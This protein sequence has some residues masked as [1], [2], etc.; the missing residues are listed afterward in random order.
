MSLSTLSSPVCIPHRPHLTAM[1]TSMKLVSVPSL[2][3]LEG[4]CGT[5]D[6]IA[7]YTQL[8][9]L[10]LYHL[11]PFSS[12]FSLPQFP[13]SDQQNI[14]S[15]D[16]A[17][18]RHQA[19]TAPSPRANIS[20]SHPPPA[21]APAAAPTATASTAASAAAAPSPT[22]PSAHNA[23]YTATDPP[24]GDRHRIANDAHTRHNNSALPAPPRAST[25]CPLVCSAAGHRIIVRGRCRR[26]TASAGAGAGAA[27]ALSLAA[28]GA[29]SG[30]GIGGTDGDWRNRTDSSGSALRRRRSRRRRLGE[31]AS[32]GRRVVGEE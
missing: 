18:P 9:L 22:A 4:F 25:A 20:S 16:T 17:E 1:A 27:R 21:D 5:A 11:F 14:T 23:D 31:R 3:I 32:F 28:V 12:I 8:L 19:S 10:F 15:T 7:K 13:Q 6:K 2:N 30:A 29:G 24:P 26:G